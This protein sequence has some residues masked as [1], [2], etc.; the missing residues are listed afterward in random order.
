MR[1]R[2]ALIALAVAAVGACARQQLPPPGQ[3]MVVITSDMPIPKDVDRIS[4]DVSSLG[5]KK[6]EQEYEVGGSALSL[7]A[8][9]G[10]V[11]GKDPSAAV[12]VRV[13]AR[14]AGKPRLIRTVVTTVPT[15]RVAA[16]RVSLH[17]LC[18][19]TAKATGDLVQST[20]PD[21]Q[22]CVAG[23]C[24]PDAV[25]AKLLPSFRPEDFFGGP[26]KACFNTVDC[27]GAVQE[28][29]L[30]KGQC[31]V[32]IPDAADT[33]KINVGLKLPLGGDGACGKEGCYIPLDADAQTGW[34]IADKRIQVVPAICKLIAGGATF[35]VVVSSSCPSKVPS[36]PPCSASTLG[37]GGT[38][39]VGPVPAPPGGV[40]AAPVP[41]SA[42]VTTLAGSGN[43]GFADG[44]NAA[45]SFYA[46]QQ[47]AADATGNIYVAD[48]LNHRIR[49]VTSTSVVST[50][51]GSG[52]AAFKDG[53]GG[54]ADFFNPVGV[55]VDGAGNLLV[56]DKDNQR[57]RKVTPA[58]VVST[59]AGKDPAGFGDGPGLAAS[60]S[61]PSGVALDAAGVLYIA[62]ES[63][64]R[65][66]KLAI[67]N[68]VTTL[69]GSGTA[70]FA[71]GKGAAA[72]FNYALG[73]AVD[74]AGN[75]YVGDT[76]NN[77]IR[78]VTPLGDVSTLAG[79]A[80]PGS[81]NGP[82]TAASF[83]YP[84]QVVVDPSGNVLVAD[85]FS[86]MIRIVTRGGVVTTLA[87]S[88]SGA[89]ADGPG[90]TAAFAGPKGVA[91]GAPGQVYVGDT[92][93]N[94]IRK[95]EVAGI[96]ELAV[97]WNLPTGGP[98]VTSYTASATAPG[99]PTKTCTAAISPCTIRGLTSGVA[100]EVSVVA[101]GASGTGAASTA[102][103]A[104]PN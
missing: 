74:K 84:A 33:A 15:D 7:P 3:L 13:I 1:A 63:N 101:T 71:D 23:S 60:F 10:I 27:L 64:N 28:A 94:R 34:K 11:A 16:L 97:T 59:L 25:D 24:A 21:G 91:A 54:G 30:D 22:S 39:P 82:G 48:T 51:A 14:Q 6:F 53:T 57:I 46:P 8:T 5:V 4:V 66:R 42:V 41:V 2:S 103:R 78:K 98:L 49:K 55:A 44:L 37:D 76:Y 90:A 31:V 62:D 93:N 89:F 96:G 86:N 40:T 73:V 72:G 19:D 61:G 50:L 92:S 67:D 45:A 52:T 20:C 80:T 87:G 100:Y 18:R 77:R 69:A 32:P 102:V 35:K 85:T 58:G 36:T 95:I 75:V 65:I 99:E 79:S 43:A 38:G 9:L 88:G 81:V 56:G 68:H 47:I 70:T 104:T 12:T 17:W 26:T 83:S 29:Q